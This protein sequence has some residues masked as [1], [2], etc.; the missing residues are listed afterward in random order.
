[1]NKKVW[2]VSTIILKCEIEE[3]PSIPNEWTCIQQ[4]NILHA[5]NREIA[6][7]KAIM[8]GQSQETTYLNATGQQISWKFVGLEN[9]EELSTKTI[10]DGTEIWGRVIHTNNPTSLV[11]NKN[12]LSV[13]FDDEIKNF[14]AKEIIIEGQETKLIC[15]RIKL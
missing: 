5:E 3:E 7:D 11:V 14:K 1:M 13:F 8:L 4:I 12:G 2:F 15:N 9:L 6:Y 10:K